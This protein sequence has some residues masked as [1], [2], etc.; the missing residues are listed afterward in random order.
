M[1]PLEEAKP[2]PHLSPH[3]A[4][5]SPCWAPEHILPRLDPPS[6]LPLAGGPQRLA[7]RF[8]ALKVALCLFDLDFQGSLGLFWMVFGKVL[9]RIQA[10]PA[11]L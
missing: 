11:W 8:S 6:S 10:D 7:Q 1:P 9:G 4:R 3:L 2:S 5:A